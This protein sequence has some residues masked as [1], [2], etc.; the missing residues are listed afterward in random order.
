VIHE[1]HL[2]VS[3]TARYW[4]LGDPGPGLREVWFVL[5]GY[6]QLAG[7]FLRHCQPLADPARLVVAPEGL[8]RFY[9]GDHTRPAGPDAKVGASWMTRE[10]RLNDIADYVTY[11]DQLYATVFDQVR[12]DD[13]TVHVLGFS[14]GTATATRWLVRGAARADRLILWGAPLPGDLDLAADGARLQGVTVT[15]VVGAKDGFLTPKVLAA[16]EAR[17]RER[18][19]P[20]RVQRFEGGHELDPDV[21]RAIVG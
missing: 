14:Q 2:T 1:H 11:L 6:A 15:L 18:G 5:H 12:R 21:L 10:D 3:R 17:L 19:I 16:D 9:V 13:V 20:Y 7:S 4:T 8:S